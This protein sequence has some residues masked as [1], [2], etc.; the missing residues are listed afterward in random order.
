MLNLLGI[1]VSG[2]V[3][4]VLARFFYPGPVE[5]GWLASIALGVGGSVLAGLIVTKGRLQDGLGQVG[6]IASILGAMALI[7]LVRVLT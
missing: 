6:W 3:V 4:G 1:I 5:M 7:F 2:L